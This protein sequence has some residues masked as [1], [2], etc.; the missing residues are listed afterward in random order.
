MK[1]TRALLRGLEALEVLAASDEPLGP[2]QL[3][4]RIGLDKATV[5]RLL[6][7]LCE[8][9]YAQVEDGGRYRLTGRIMQLAGGFGSQSGLRELARPH[10]ERLRDATDETVHLGVR[11][12]DRVSYIDKVPG[13]HPV[14]LV[15]E[16]GRAMPLHTTALGK[17][18]LAWMDD[19]DRL[20]VLAELELAPRTER[21][22]TSVDELGRELIR[23]R[24]RGYA[25]DDRENE[26]HAYC[27]GA[28]VLDRDGRLV[29]MV[30]L[31]GPSYRVAERHRDHGELVRST[32]AAVSAVLAEQPRPARTGLN[33]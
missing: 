28:P 5:N 21:S 23:T 6:F 19:D 7:T 13:T 27:V 4:R 11:D 9:G 25:I 2:T 22:I 10:L 16:V 33:G 31:S 18:A 3:A 24:E 29:A 1:P 30:S 26:E 14:R 20:R 32:A 8:A 17:V 15:S 12:G